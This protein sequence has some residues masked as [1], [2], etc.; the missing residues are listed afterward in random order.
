[1]NGPAELRITRQR[2]AWRDRFRSYRVLLDDVEVGRLRNGGEQVLPIAPG[3]HSLQIRI[4]WAGSEKRLFEAM[5]GEE[6]G[7]VCGARVRPALAV[8]ELL[9]SAVRR[10]SWIYLDRR[11]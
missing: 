2:F 3:W 6:V 11:T 9:R 5:P 1:M 10:E 7:F 4:D 8:F